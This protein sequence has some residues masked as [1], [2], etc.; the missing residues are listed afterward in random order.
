MFRAVARIPLV[1]TAVK[2]SQ[3]KLVTEIIQEFSSW[4]THV[5]RLRAGEAAV[6][7]EWTAGPIPLVQGWLPPPPPP[8]SAPKNC[9]GWDGVDGKL[10][11]NATIVP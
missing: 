11:C 1:L 8:P 2:V 4:C 7:V 6:E 10:G 3:G 5:V 9:V